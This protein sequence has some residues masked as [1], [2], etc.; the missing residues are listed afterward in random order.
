MCKSSGPEMSVFMIS[1][2]NLVLASGKGNKKLPVPGLQGNHTTKELRKGEVRYLLS[3]NFRV[4]AFLI[5][6]AI[7]RSENR[8]KRS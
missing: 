7:L 8:F 3:C 2:S 5:G 1:L 4:P 6:A